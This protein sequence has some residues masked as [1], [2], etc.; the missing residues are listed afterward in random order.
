MEWYINDLSL[1]G[2]FADSHALRASLE[3]ILRL[4]AR[5]T[6]L[7]RQ[8]LCSRTLSLRPVTASMN[9]S[10]TVL[11][12]RDQLFIRQVL[13]WVSSAGPFWNDERV[14]NP[15]DYFRFE[16][17][18]VTDQGLGEAAR[19]LVL[20]LSAAS[21]SFRH[22][23]QGFERTPL[24]VEHGLEEDP[25][26]SYDVDNCWKPEDIEAAAARPP[27]SWA[28]LLEMTAAQMDGLILSNDIADQLQPVPF[29]S[30]VA[31]KFFLLLGILQNLTKEKRE[32]AFT[33]AG[34]ELHNKHF[35]GKKALFTDES[36]ANKQDFA[37]ELT[38]RDPTDS[39]KTLF[40]SWHGKVKFGS[41]YRI[42]FEWKPPK[43]QEKIKVVY[44]G[45]K[46]TK[47]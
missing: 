4:M 13:Q 25:L 29:H 21:F 8:I 37:A 5:R 16:G 6:D 15:D 46:I 38:F 42:H 41:Q 40:C 39:S 32:G 1:S 11:A 47:R 7:K 3:P 36:D 9:L 28:D 22:I 14:A 45:P 44:I 27:Q 23:D 18:N 34:L 35:V 17:E 30:G 24:C 12:T 31:E 26:G 33:P 20:D 19:R 2:Q 43:G 10:E